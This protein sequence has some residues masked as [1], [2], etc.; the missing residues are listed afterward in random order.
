MKQFLVLQL[1]TADIEAESPIAWFVFDAEE[2]LLGRGASPLSQLRAEVGA[3]FSGGETLVLVPG[4]LV[5]LTQVRIP[6]RQLRQIKQALPYMV[7]ELIADNIEEVHMALPNGKAEVDA[8][9]AVAV[10][11]H[12]LLINWLDQLYQY[13]IQPDW[14]SPDSLAVPWREHSKSFFVTKQR[15]LYRD[16]PHNAQ[17]LFLGHAD[18][19]L[20]LLKTQTGS[21]EIG[22][23]PRYLIGAGIEDADR[24]QAVS[25]AVAERL[26]V[27]P[28][29]TIY[30]ETGPEVLAANALRMRDDTIN[31]LQGGYRMQQRR[32]NASAWRRTAIA[33]SIGLLI[34]CGVSA[35]SGLWFSWRADQIEARTISLYR[36]LFPQERRVVSPRKQMQ[37]HLVGS[38]AG[39]ASPLPLLAKTALGLRNNNIQ[40]D[41]LRYSQQRNDLQ[42]QLRA[43]TLDVFDRIKQQLDGVGLSVEINSAAERGSE[44]VG[45]INIKERQS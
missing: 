12:H 23:L 4:E 36:E 20:G 8:P 35:A 40:L 43:P 15:L 30:A 19:L 21:A 38:V 42:L 44:T 22:A 7:E 41:E 10:I 18:T 37:A 5:L 31:L 28:E 24:A 3:I 39:G 29:T 17:A 11:R 26:Q 1:P 9:L 14:M 16:G 33:A 6:S 45:R 32:G 2:S 25:E 13:G 27:E 34:F